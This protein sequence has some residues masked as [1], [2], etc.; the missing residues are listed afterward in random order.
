MVTDGAGYRRLLPVTIGI[1]GPQGLW[2]GRAT[3]NSAGRGVGN[4]GEA[5]E[6]IIPLILHV[7]D[8]DAQ[9]QRQ[10]TLLRQASVMWK[11]GVI[12][13]NP[14]APDYGEVIVP[15]R[16]VLVT[17]T[18]NPANY[19]PGALRDGRLFSFRTTSTVLHEDVPLTG[20]FNGVLEGIVLM[21]AT[22]PL[23]PFMHRYHPDHG[24][25]DVVP[26][27][28]GGYEFS[29]RITLEFT[30]TDPQ[31]SDYSE[32]PGWGDYV[33]GGHYREVI[34]GVISPNDDQPESQTRHVEVGGNF[35][36]W[37]VSRVGVLN[38][39]E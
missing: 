24:H 25:P 30:S 26:D 27:A 34:R 8:E 23:N 3:L 1:E 12:Q 16:S 36:L 20:A 2:V 5:P 29:R 10:V 28:L 17:S 21:P 6:T 19:S 38:D 4:M 32:P 39:G 35:Y 14:G 33:V 31:G 15:G 11:E 9:Q 22:H 18:G 13:D 7:S 37:R